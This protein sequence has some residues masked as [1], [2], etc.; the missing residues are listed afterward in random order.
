MSFGIISGGSI[1]KNL[2]LKMTE[3]SDIHKYSIFNSQYSF[4][5]GVPARQ[6][7]ILTWYLKAKE[8][9]LKDRI[10]PSIIEQT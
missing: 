1:I 3:R 7:Y 8:L 10:R 6:A 2:S 9:N 5:F 4:F